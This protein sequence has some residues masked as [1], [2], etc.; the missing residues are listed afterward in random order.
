MKIS[1]VMPTYNSGIYIKKAIDSVLDQPYK[2]K[3]LIVIDGGSNDNTVEILKSY[4][5]KIKW[6]SEKDNGQADA[7]NKGLKMTSG[8]I[9]AWLN[10]D[11]YYEPNILND[12]S[13]S[14][15]NNK[16]IVLVYGNQKSVSPKSTMINVP[17]SK[18]TT[19]KMIRAGN[20]IHQPASFY[21]LDAVKKI[22][23]LNAGLKY[24][25][26]YDLFIKLSKIGNF[27]YINKML[28]N[29]TVRPDQKSDS[30]NIINMDKELIKIS[31]ENGGK[32]LS[33]IRLSAI[34]HHFLYFIKKIK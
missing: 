20:F 8:E 14:F 18:I 9:V 1:I 33:K 5:E 7:I 19:K 32:F 3:E 34:Y 12:I 16:E 4:G 26:E 22:S 27:L 2:D 23:Y 28:A 6:I 29:F 25:M 30:K 17:P 10:A 11:D 13:K 31:K 21:R 24:W 15:S